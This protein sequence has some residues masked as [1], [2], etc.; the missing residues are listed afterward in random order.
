MEFNDRR[1][2]EELPSRTY[3]VGKYS[4]TYG[5]NEHTKSPEAWAESWKTYNSHCSSLNDDN[6]VTHGTR[7]TNPVPDKYAQNHIEKTLTKMRKLT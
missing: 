6:S 4:I 3:D 5:Y 2:K 1:K 7:G